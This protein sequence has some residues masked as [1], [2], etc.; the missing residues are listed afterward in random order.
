MP[1]TR[2]GSSGYD[3]PAWPP[4]GL[5]I[6]YRDDGDTASQISVAV[7]SVVAVI[8]VQQLVDSILSALRL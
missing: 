3:P 6:L 2:A 1:C 7:G 4:K 5:A 8:L